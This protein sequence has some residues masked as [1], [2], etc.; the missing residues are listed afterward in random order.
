MIFFCLNFVLKLIFFLNLVEDS[1]LY[2]NKGTKALKR[3]ISVDASVLNDMNIL[4]AADVLMAERGLPPTIYDAY[5][6]FHDE[7]I[8]FATTLAERMQEYGLMVIYPIH[9]H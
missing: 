9:L 1:I 8:E 6:L 3:P 4:T 5:L 7:D 2:L